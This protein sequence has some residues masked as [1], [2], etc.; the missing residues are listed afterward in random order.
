LANCLYYLEKF[1]TKIHFF[2]VYK[3]REQESETGPFWGVGISGRRKIVE[4][5]FGRVNMGKYCIYI[6]EHGKVDLLKLF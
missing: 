4:K 5:R 6:Y 3:I 2:I 1:Q